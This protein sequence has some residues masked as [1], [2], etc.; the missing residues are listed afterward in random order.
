MSAIPFP[1]NPFP[2]YN[3]DPDTTL[4]WWIQV[5]M[6]EPECVFFYGPFAT[7]REAES[8]L[9]GY[10]KDLLQEGISDMSID[11]QQ[12]RFEEISIADIA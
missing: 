10:V 6:K 11:I 4:C 2:L 5:S 9:S 8:Q 1:L 7:Q 3:D 12:R